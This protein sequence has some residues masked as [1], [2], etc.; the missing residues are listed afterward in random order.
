MLSKCLCL[1]W[2]RIEGSLDEQNTVICTGF[3]FIYVFKV[4]KQDINRMRVTLFGESGK[5]FEVTEL[6]VCKPSETF[7]KYKSMTQIRSYMTRKSSLN[8]CVHVH[9]CVVEQGEITNLNL[10]LREIKLH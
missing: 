1:N 8:L 3:L 2:L 7:S 6:T 5:C 4:S 9:E 10:G